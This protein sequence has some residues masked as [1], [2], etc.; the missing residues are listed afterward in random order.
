MIVPQWV[1]HRDPRWFRDPE[2]FKPER[3]ALPE[4]RPRG[5]YF[6]FGAG[7]RQ[8]VGGGFAVTA[9]V[10]MLATMATRVRLERAPGPPVRLEPFMSLRPSHGLP[11]VVRRRAIDPPGSRA[12][13]RIA[14]GPEMVR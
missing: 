7:Q 12:I 9:A 2:T 11:M 4:A 6:P 8:C 10:L 13:L 5:A 14:D 1:I 3:W